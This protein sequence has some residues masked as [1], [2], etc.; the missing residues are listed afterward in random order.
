MYVLRKGHA[1]ARLMR[2][3]CRA[4]FE[5]RFYLDVLFGHS[6]SILQGMKRVNKKHSCPADRTTGV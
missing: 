2:L 1:A 4:P 3:S 6:K 5:D